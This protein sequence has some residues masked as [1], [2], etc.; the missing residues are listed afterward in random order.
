MA[1]ESSAEKWRKAALALFC[2]AAGAAPLAVMAAAAEKPAKMAEAPRATSTS[3]GPGNPT[4]KYSE[5]AAL[6]LRTLE[7][8][9]SP[10]GLS[11][12][13]STPDQSAYAIAAP[14][15][16]EPLTL[17]AAVSI[18]V[19]RHPA[20]ADAVSQTAQASGL[21]DVARAAYYPQI[22]A[23]LGN[24]KYTSTGSGNTASLRISQM[25]YDFGKTAGVVDQAEAQVKRQ[26]ASTFLEV[27]SIEQQT[28]EAVI[29]AHRYQVL[30]GIATQQVEAVKKVYE[31]SRL[32]ANAGVSTR[33]DPIQAETRL[34]NAETNHIQIKAQY[35]QARQRLRTLLG[36]PFDGDIAA[37]PEGQ[38]GRV[39]LAEMPDTSLMPA[40]LVAQAEALVAQH[41]LSI[42][43]ANRLPTVSLDYALNKNLTGVNAS[44]YTRHG[45]DQSLMVNLSWPVYRGG[46]LNAQ[47]RAAGFGLEAARSRVDVARLNGS[48]L[49]RGYREQ[50][51]G[52]K[53]RMP[54]MDSRKKSISEARDI[55]REQ[56]K[57]GTRSIL[58]L[59]NAE[60]EYYQAASEE[61][62]VRH[63]YWLA[64]VGYVAAT[65]TGGEFY[66]LSA[67][68]V[69]RMEPRS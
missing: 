52:A 15:P 34:L 11:R 25:L 55:Y 9:M 27:Q 63:D 17:N 22:T 3:D 12:E 6:E 31:M 62:A 66:G 61:E 1:Q 44:T 33:S 8:A 26:Q 18:A 20:I 46:A 48:D 68:A 30:L 21:V 7:R 19:G 36:G 14:V 32:R 45:T 13:L 38:A 2:M 51:L 57:L 53:G 49:A 42:A 37:L 54:T 28:A 23:G 29:N 5:T 67:D 64:L 43:E 58:D 60:Q 69:A 40:V 39:Q 41:E 56:Y 47:V 50:A 24:G 16:S 10:Q 65:G 35:D 4:S 59:L